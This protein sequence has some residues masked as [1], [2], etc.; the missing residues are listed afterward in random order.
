PLVVKPAALLIDPDVA[1][2]QAEHE[3]AALPGVAVIRRRGDVEPDMVHV[4]K[5]AAHLA[6]E[7][8]PAS[9]R[10]APRP[11]QNLVIREIRIELEHHLQVRVEATGRHYDGLAADGHRLTGLGA[12]TV[13]AGHAA[14]LEPQPCDFRLRNDLAALL[15]EAFDEATHQAQAVELGP[16]PAQRGVAFLGFEVD[17]LHAEAFGPVVEIVERVLDIVTGPDRVGRRT[18]PFDP[19]LEGKIR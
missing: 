1:G 11:F 12:A 16:R 2:H 10:A 13:E 7:F 5:I 17:P 9:R 18:S 8:V 19:I 6:N 3:A 14:A 4:R 15:T